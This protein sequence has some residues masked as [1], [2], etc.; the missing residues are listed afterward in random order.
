MTKREQ[1]KINKLLKTKR[2]S[3]AAAVAAAPIVGAKRVTW[4]HQFQLNYFDDHDATVPKWFEESPHEVAH[5]RYSGKLCV[6]EVSTLEN[7]GLSWAKVNHSE[8]EW[9]PEWYARTRQLNLTSLLPKRCRIFD[10]YG[11]RSKC[12]MDVN[13]GQQC[14]ASK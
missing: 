14:L 10:D 9:A 3:V 12:K 11:K 4:S 13:R 8:K 1:H 2:K 7:T 6:M 5:L